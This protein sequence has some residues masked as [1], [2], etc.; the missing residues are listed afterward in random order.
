MLLLVFNKSEIHLDFQ[1]APKIC[2]D[3]QGCD[4]ERVKLIQ[5]LIQKIF[6]L[7]I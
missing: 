4:K 3:L 2:Q 1:T 6:E 5:G 7:S